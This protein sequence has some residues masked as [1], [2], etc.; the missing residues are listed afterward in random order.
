[1]LSIK[2]DAFLE[3]GL[4]NMADKQNKYGRRTIAL[5]W[6]VLISIFIGILLY[7]EQIALLYVIATLGLVVL[8]LIVAFADL[9]RVGRENIEGFAPKSEL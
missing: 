6:I 7:L 4:M 2:N 5:F 1:L 9:E 8:L 3:S